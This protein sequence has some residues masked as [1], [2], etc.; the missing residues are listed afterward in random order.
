MNITG[1]NILVWLPSPLGDAI[2]CTPALR[3]IRNKFP[4]AQISFLA[5][6]TV[7]DALSPSNFCDQWIENSKKSP[8]VKNIKDHDSAIL[9]KNSFDSAFTVFR[10][11]ITERIGYSREFRGMFLT[12]KIQPEKQNKTF[13]PIPAIDYYLHLCRQI[14]CD[15]SDR[16][17]ELGVSQSDLTY[18]QNLFS[19]IIASDKPLIIFVPGGAF[20]PSKLWK[21]ERFAT[22]ADKLVE[23]YD[24]NIIVS[25]APNDTEIRIAKQICRTANSKDRLLNLGDY[26]LTLG[27][28]KALYSHAALVITNDTG[29]RHIAVAL[30]RK[31]ISMFGPNNPEWTRSG[32]PDEIQIQGSGDCVPCDSPICERKTHLC[33][34]SITVEKVF[35][36]ACQMLGK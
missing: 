3:A 7:R 31:V 30:K 9:F 2:M 26:K 10:A 19:E 12:G 27:Q 28:L 16:T 20:G 23:K 18:A 33:M 13:K 14:G 36:T 6:A 32:Y 34:D 5:S 4:N 25:V 17:M 35:N 29:P 24:A 11:G 1:R 15:V 22:L 21:S 8:V